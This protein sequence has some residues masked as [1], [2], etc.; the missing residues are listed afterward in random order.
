MID[1]MSETAWNLTIN[2]IENT[3]RS[4][5][6]KVLRDISVNLDTKIIRAEKLILLGNIFLD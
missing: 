5:C 2:D 6:E 3:L 4:S 1:V